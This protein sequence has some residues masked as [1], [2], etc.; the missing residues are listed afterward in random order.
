MKTT[1][2][3]LF[4]FHY[5]FCPIKEASLLWIHETE[6]ETSQSK[7]NRETEFQT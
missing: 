3:K 6:E 4:G 7:N 5:I 1:K 2:P